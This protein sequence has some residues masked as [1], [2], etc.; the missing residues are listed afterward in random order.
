MQPILTA[1]APGQ[2][3][4]L[5]GL[6]QQ[7]FNLNRSYIMS[8]SSANLLQNFYLE[9]GLE[10]FRQKPEGIHWGWEAPTCQLRGHFLGHW[11][12]GAAHL[13]DATGD[14]EAKAK[15]DFIVSELARCQEANG[16]EWVGSIPEKYMTWITQGKPVWAPQYTLHKTLMGLYDMYA[17]AGNQQA[18]DIL[19]NWARWFHRWTGQF[20]R[21]QLDD[22][23]DVETGGM[24]E[25]W[26]NLYGVTGS[27]EHLELLNRYDRPR[28]FEPLLAGNDVLTN[29]HANTT[30]PEVL[31]AARAWEVTGDDRWRAIVEAYWHSAVTARG[32]FATGGQTCGEIWT[33]P[34]EQAAR[35]GDKN[36]E[37]CTVYNMM[38]LADWL[39]RWTGDLAYADYWERNLYNGIL[40]QQHA[41]TGMITYFLPLEAGAAKK[42]GT[43]T[44]DFWCC[45]GSLVQA[46]TLHNSAVYFEDATGLLVAQY[47]PTE[48]TWE[49]S[50][51]PIRITQKFDPQRD[52]TRRPGTNV[53]QISIACAEPAEFTLK[54]RLPW[55]LDGAPTIL[56]NGETVEVD[57]GARLVELR[58]TWR[59][60]RIELALPKRL[61]S[62]ALDDAPDT[63]AFMD[64][65]VVLAGL[66]DEERALVGDKDDPRTLLTPDNERE[67][68][69]WHH[70]YR[71]QNQARNIRFLP[72]YEVTDQRYTVY[73][74]IQPAG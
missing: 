27:A 69:S 32:Y 30:I 49:R 74:P 6:F 23:L 54:L 56:V 43:P 4:L 17:L 38:L 63:V 61:S 29:M 66:C 51:V 45:H 62:Y 65:P 42:W 9:A 24:L 57:A 37:H 15:A 11:L 14:A 41:S 28:L 35:L 19:I 33:P 13:Y 67:W 34:H 44:D 53:V 73:F 20:S 2:V 72:L 22:I 48:L 1:I 70:G 46:H 52:L 7:R 18:L 21:P 39:L 58:R 16:G 64:G 68:G 55:W 71:T 12:S 47:I 60:D 5:P 50:G 36:Q 40:A 8:L 25:V 26:A 59:E 10:S 3:K 31:G